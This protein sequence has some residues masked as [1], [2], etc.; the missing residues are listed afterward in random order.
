MEATLQ[1][2]SS[3][4]NKTKN[5]D[6]IDIRNTQV[7]DYGYLKTKKL[8]K[9]FSILKGNYISA[10]EMYAFSLSHNSKEDLDLVYSRISCSYSAEYI[11]KFASYFAEELSLRQMRDLYK[12]LVNSGS[13]Y[14]ISQFVK[15]VLPKINAK[16]YSSEERFC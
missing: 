5:Y 4:L 7:Q 8:L 11:Y 16:D 9:E 12:E 1:E 3:V 6:E 13:E 2:K 14:Y 10:E 15:N